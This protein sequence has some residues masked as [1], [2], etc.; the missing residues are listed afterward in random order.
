MSTTYKSHYPPIC[1]Q[2]PVSGQWY[3]IANGKWHPVKRQYSWK[4]IESVW[5]RTE[6]VERKVEVNVKMAYIVKGSKGNEYEVTNNEG[7]WSCTCPA[8]GF[9]RGKDCKHIKQ[10]KD[11]E[12]KSAK[13]K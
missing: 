7:F 11:E 12:L 1:L 2:G 9:G 10:I 5:E 13:R 8:H 4:E 3:I 6:Y